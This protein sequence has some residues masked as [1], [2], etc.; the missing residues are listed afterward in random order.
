[1]RIKIHTSQAEKQ[2]AYR[3][4]LKQKGIKDS[5]ID[6]LIDWK[7]SNPS[8]KSK[9]KYER[10]FIAIDTEGITKNNN[11]I[12]CLLGD[13]LGN[14]CEDYQNG[15]STKLAF[16]FLL[17]IANKSSILIGYS[18][19][20]DINMIL[21]DL[22][23]PEL[24]RIA[25]GLKTTV[26]LNNSRYIIEWFPGKTFY[27]GLMDDNRNIIKTALVYDVFG[28]FQKAFVK[29]A[30]EFNVVT[31]EEDLFLSEM[32]LDRSNFHESDKEKIRKYNHLECIVLVRVMNSLRESMKLAQCVPQRWNG[33]G[34]IAGTLLKQNGIKE[35]NYTPPD[36]LPYFLGA[37]FGGRIQVLKMGEHENVYT[38]DIISAYPAAMVQLP[39]AI[40]SWKKIKTFKPKS[41]WACYIVEWNLPNN[42]IITPFPLRENLNGTRVISYPKR[43]KGVYWFPEVE[44]ALKH[45]SK[46]IKIHYGFEFKPEEEN[47]FSW[48][49]KLFE[50]RR[51]FKN[52][53]DPKIQSAQL[54]VK[55]GINSLYGKTAQGIGYKGRT[56]AFQNYFWSGY[57]T[58]YTRAKMFDL[59]MQFP[60]EIIAFAT[61]GIFSTVKLA[62]SGKN[63]GE[64]E[65]DFAK[66]LFILKAGLY[67]FSDSPDLNC[68]DP[69][70]H[71]GCF[72]HSR[73]SR[74]HFLKDVN[75]P[76]L[77]K[78]WRDKNVYGKFEY[79]TVKF[80]G[81]KVCLA[82][83]DD[84]Y[85]DKWRKWIEVEREINF[86]P[87]N[88]MIDDKTYDGKTIRLIPYK[89][90]S[91]SLP[92]EPKGD[93]YEG[94]E[95]QNYLME[96]DQL[97]SFFDE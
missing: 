55:L 68:Y 72:H 37:Y 41:K 5:R 51:E 78:I 13:S 74:G 9:R 76:T 39:S 83:S 92:Y 1:M 40:G 11:H 47:A 30:R 19:G 27:V 52:S 69:E 84:K 44:Q 36:M 34:A 94:E 49:Q 15:I 28:F 57:T 91:V 43:G 22:D 10:K 48:I 66:Y 25:K 23:R 71:K 81:L 85:L 4:R 33:A 88:Q 89:S 6:R 3:T 32:K 42:C 2:K 93:W 20:Y 63:L 18:I 96:L 17:S 7:I 87:S 62:E 46:Y 38:H 54:P 14:Y 97:D 35:K 70:N 64:W 73:K 16:D 77:Q 45:Y 82:A 95:G 56:P 65:C 67:V 58:S 26:Y 75:F 79:K 86:F 31:K 12:C 29:T 8:H 24:E 53:T 80:F 61:D 21:R 59:A 50:S 60:K 90:N